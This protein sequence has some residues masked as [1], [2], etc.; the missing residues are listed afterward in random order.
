M[1]KVADQFITLTAELVKL[2]LSKV[3][4]KYNVD[5]NSTHPGILV[6]A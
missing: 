1:L 5:L 3:F 4:E 2:F 6:L